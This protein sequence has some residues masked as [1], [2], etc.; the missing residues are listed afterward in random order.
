MND[1]LLKELKIS[2]MQRISDSTLDVVY[3]SGPISSY[4]GSSV[5]DNIQKFDHYEKTL[6]TE[7]TLPINPASV[8]DLESDG[9]HYDDI[10]DMWLDIL[11]HSKLKKV[12][13]LPNWHRSNGATKEHE[14]SI[15]LGKEIIYLDEEE[16]IVLR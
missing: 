16:S 15:K 14:L 12:Y 2:I 11:S 5:R 10:L 9:H 8:G 4:P 13:M 3:I 6:S 1:N 7:N